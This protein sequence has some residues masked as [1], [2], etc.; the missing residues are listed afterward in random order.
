MVKTQFRKKRRN[1]KKTMRRQIKGGDDLELF[2]KL[3]ADVRPPK[4]DLERFHELT[5]DVRPPKSDLERF[6]ELTA[7][8]RPSQSKILN[9]RQSKILNRMK[10]P[11][12]NF[13]G[14]YK[15]NGS[16]FKSHYNK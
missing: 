11:S 15:P 4:S 3:T 10:K 8:V 14:R 1:T 2:H 12:T 6:H 9:P 16:I 7:D 5:A 13:M